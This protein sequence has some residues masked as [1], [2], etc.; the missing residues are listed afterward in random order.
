MIVKIKKILAHIL[1]LFFVM[2]L[3]MLAYSADLTAEQQGNKQHDLLRSRHNEQQKNQKHLEEK[4][5]RERK[6][7]EIDLAPLMSPR[8]EKGGACFPIKN[9]LL[10]GATKIEREKQA[11]FELEAREKC[12]DAASIKMLIYNITRYYHDAGF[13]AAFI[14]IPPQKLQQETLTLNV[15]EGEIEEIRWEKE[16]YGNALEIKT[17]FPFLENK[18]LNLR[19][20]EQGLDQ[21]NRLPSNHVTMQ[22][23]PGS[24]KGKTI[25]LLKNE[26]EKTL[27]ANFS[28]SNSGQKATGERMATMRLEKDNFLNLNDNF[29]FT[30]GR[31]MDGER[32]D[33][34]MKYY[35][36]DWSVPFGDWRFSLESERSDYHTTFE[37]G[38][39]KYGSDGN[40]GANIARVEKMLFRNKTHKL[41]SQF[42][43]AN[44]ESEN[45]QN[46]FKLSAA[47]RS[48]TNLYWG[49][50]HTWYYKDSIVSSDFQWTK[51]TKLF[52]AYRDPNDLTF[53][54]AK[55]Q[56]D[57]LNANLDFS[58][59]L[60]KWDSG[61]S[62]D[63]LGS[64]RAQISNDTLYGNERL[65][66]GSISAVRGFKEQ[67]ILGDS[68]YFFRNDFNYTI[69]VS[70]SDARLLPIFG[71]AIQTFA[72]I[73][74]GYVRV[75]GG[76]PYNFG[77]GEGYM[78]G[79]GLGVRNLGGRVNFEMR[80]DRPIRAP[81]FI[82]KE[83][84][85]LYV[86]IGV[87]F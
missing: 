66:L 38:G 25:I 27:R 84:H 74:G 7:L 10:A 60:K 39:I 48:F 28:Y 9:L 8:E 70:W 24:S 76:K 33:K 23:L 83:N 69:P 75:Q 36:F 18:I 40:S 86:N 59:P 30:Q 77:E 81:K 34:N 12:L 65:V 45:Y 26:R 17:A 85:E 51:G 80:Y 1:A 73:D 63:Y 50:E 54:S 82:H 41:N 49:L 15:I 29:S 5:H 44:Y 22:L 61:D 4:K 2:F 43:I 20:I 21:L 19:E 87:G 37:N 47:D 79:A 46:G 6:N 11:A 31:D 67:T 32:W 13:V 72:G 64:L 55:A 52:D 57:K 16:E 56:F 78:S 14:E 62:F 53:D 35:S 3:P 42:Q 58:K 68:G 71:N